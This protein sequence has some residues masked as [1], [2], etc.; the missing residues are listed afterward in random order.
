MIPL[1]VML[2]RSDGTVSG[3]G[4]LPSDAAARVAIEGRTRRF[5]EATASRLPA[6]QLIA[7]CSTQSCAL[8]CKSFVEIAS[9]GTRLY[10]G[11]PRAPSGWVSMTPSDVE[12][13]PRVSGSL[14]MK[15]HVSRE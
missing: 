11:A 12:S 6:V 14:P 9:H 10:F 13:A 8:P 15:C 5:T 2:R 7:T 1:I 3:E 4:I